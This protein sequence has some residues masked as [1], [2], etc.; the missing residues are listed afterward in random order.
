[1]RLDGR[2]A[3]QRDHLHITYQLSGDV[4]SVV[5]PPF[6]NERSGRRADN[7]WQHTCFELF[8]AAE[9]EDPYWEVNLAPNGAWNLYR[10]AAYRKGLAPEPD[11]DA[12]P[13]TVSTHPGALVLTLDLRLPRELY[14]A[15]RRRP[16]CLGVTAVIERKGRELSYWALAHGGP[17]ADFHR[18]E[19]FIL[20]FGHG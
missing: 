11:R 2:L 13:F 19:D 20:R 14:L 3:L 5:L 9:G 18:R 16:L 6:S 1:V 17:N 10:L 4:P 8:L 7:L 12:L 15:C